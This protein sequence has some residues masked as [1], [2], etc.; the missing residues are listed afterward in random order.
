MEA[1]SD[2]KAA[3]LS[4]DT[5]FCMLDRL[6]Y[7]LA[8]SAI[9]VIRHLPLAVCF[10]LGQAVGAVLW[11]ILPRYRKLARE[12]LSVA[13]ALTSSKR[14]KLPDPNIRRTATGRW[15][16]RAKPTRRFQLPFVTSKTSLAEL[17]EQLLKWREQ[18]RARL[19][20]S[21]RTTPGQCISPTVLA[22]AGGDL[23]LDLTAPDR[24]ALTEQH[25]PRHQVECNP[26]FLRECRWTFVHALRRS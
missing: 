8:L 23:Q 5:F 24:R 21:S 15:R 14:R 17:I 6:T 16:R 3:L 26:C 13:L 1:P 10:V 12:N 11:A 7:W 20:L 4:L 22:S 25:C 18:L 9:T 19:R 2:A